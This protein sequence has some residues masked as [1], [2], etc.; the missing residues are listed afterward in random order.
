MTDHSAYYEEVKCK[1]CGNGMLEC[2]WMGRCIDCEVSEWVLG[3]G[4]LTEP[5]AKELANNE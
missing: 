1:R 3:G 5:E 2:D 4:W